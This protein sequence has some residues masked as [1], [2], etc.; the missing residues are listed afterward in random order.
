MASRGTPLPSALCGGVGGLRPAD[1]RTQPW[2]DKECS[3]RGRVGGGVLLRPEAWPSL[4][5]DDIILPQP[6]CV[7][8]CFPETHLSDFS[9]QG[10]P[11]KNVPL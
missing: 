2:Q 9:S 6:G 1:N 11:S 8:G 3:L 5:A 10:L 4:C 7:Y